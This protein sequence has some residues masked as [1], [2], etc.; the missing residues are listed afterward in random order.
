MEQLVRSWLGS[1]AEPLLNGEI[2]AEYNEVLSHGLPLNSA[3]I[4]F[5]IMKF[6][7]FT[8]NE[9]L[10]LLSHDQLSNENILKCIT[11]IDTVA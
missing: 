1:L 3:K 6:L 8:N 11:D 5:K 4:A 10:T 7:T 2:S 9:I